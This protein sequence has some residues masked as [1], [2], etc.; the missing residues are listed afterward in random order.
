[1]ASIDENRAMWDETYRWSDGGD[2]WSSG[3][4]GARSQWERWVEPRIDAALAGRPVQLVVEVGCGHGRWTRFLLERFPHV[5]AFDLAPRCVEACRSRLGADA[6]LDVRVC[7]GRSLPGVD[8]GSVDLV[9][10]IDSLVHADAAAMS[11]YVAECARVL[12]ADGVAVLHHSNLGACGL[13]AW[14]LLQRPRVRRALAALGVAEP[15]VH[16]RDPSVDADLVARLA[17]ERSLWC[18]HQELIRWDTR[19]RFTDCISVLR[20]PSAGAGPTRRTRCTTFLDQ[21]A[22]AAEDVDGSGDATR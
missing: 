9:V 12:A 14:P 2:E 16:W 18:S 15:G 1:M 21:M 20:R 5:V 4:G 7:D 6:G 10:S 22:A 13:D 8:P 11:A 17:A 3:W 19:R